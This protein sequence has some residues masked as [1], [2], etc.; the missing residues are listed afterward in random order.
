[1]LHFSF[2]IDVVIV[3]FLLSFLIFKKN[4]EHFK[5]NVLVLCFH[6]ITDGHHM[7][8]FIVK[9]LMN[10]LSLAFSFRFMHEL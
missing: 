9:L 8:A 10:Y 3:M 5:K 1:M 7:D 2:E 6:F 4:D